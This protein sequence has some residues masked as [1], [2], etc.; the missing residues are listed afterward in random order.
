MPSRA[1]EMRHRD[2]YDRDIGNARNIGN[3]LTR[4]YAKGVSEY[5]P[6]A[7]FRDAV[8]AAHSRF[9]EDF[10]DDIRQLRG[11]NVRRGRLDTGFGFMDEDRL[12]RDSQDRLQRHTASLALQTGAQEQRRLDS[13][14]NVGVALSGRAM[15]ASAS[16][17]H[18]AQDRRMQ[19]RQ[20]RRSGIGAIIGAGIGAAGSVLGGPIGA[21]IFGLKNMYGG[22]N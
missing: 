21:A 18:T 5:D 4:Q 19:E 9:R 22:G 2:A 13:V 16:E 3:S 20:N 10:T 7:S 15:D 6:R 12:W 1:R 11:S 17:Y 8:G 14:G